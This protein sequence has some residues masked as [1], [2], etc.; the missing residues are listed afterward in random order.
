MYTAGCQCFSFSQIL[1]ASG[2]QTP[3]PVQ[4]YV[5][6][7]CQKAVDFPLS[8]VQTGSSLM[9]GSNTTPSVPLPPDKSSNL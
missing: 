2:L 6:K 3:L 5:P 7:G 9:P 8:G 1:C 4:S